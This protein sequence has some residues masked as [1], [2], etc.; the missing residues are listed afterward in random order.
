SVAG[1]CT[2]DQVN[3]T[4]DMQLDAQLM[5]ARFLQALPRPDVKISG[6]SAEFKAHLTQ[7][8]TQQN[9]TGNL[10]LA[11]LN[12]RY[13]EYSFKSFAATADLEIGMTPQQAQ[14]RK[15]SGKLSEGGKPGGTFEL[16]GTYDLTNKAAQ[17]NAKLSDFNQNGLRPF[18][19]P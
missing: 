13:G 1:S 19:E 12:G 18:L 8:Q 9:I 6:G 7:K 3:N 11:D 5:L 15:I 14:I 4:A 10:A 17:M 2:Y 16:S